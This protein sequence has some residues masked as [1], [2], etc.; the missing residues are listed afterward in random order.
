VTY[1]TEFYKKFGERYP[2]IQN[3]IISPVIYP[4]AH[5]SL[6]CDYNWLK[7]VSNGI[8]WNGYVPGYANPNVN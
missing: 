8:I 3:G 1:Q 6:K 2:Q 7:D 5:L 4:A